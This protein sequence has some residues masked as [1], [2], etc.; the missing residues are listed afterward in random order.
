MLSK[1][2]LFAVIIRERSEVCAKTNFRNRITRIIANVWVDYLRLTEESAPVGVVC[3][4]FWH[5]LG[6]I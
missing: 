1:C 4:G 3:S 5:T 6:I 2:F